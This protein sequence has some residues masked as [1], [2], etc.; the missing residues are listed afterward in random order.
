MIII[1]DVGVSTQYKVLWLTIS[2]VL[3]Q[4][5]MQKQA[6]AGWLAIIR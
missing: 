1:Y 3:Q 2:K 5:R 4:G 6:V